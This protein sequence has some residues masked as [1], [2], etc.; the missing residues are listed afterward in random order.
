M[1]AKSADIGAA[2]HGSDT[3]EIGKCYQQRHNEYKRLIVDVSHYMVEAYL[4]HR[5]L[6]EHEDQLAAKID[7]GTE[8][9]I[10][11]QLLVYGHNE[12]AT[13]VTSDA[14][15]TDY[16]DYLR[17]NTATLPAQRYLQGLEII[18]GGD[19]ARGITWVELYA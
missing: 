13:K 7:E 2:L 11:F 17:K 8:K 9:R 5:K 1:Y 16:P 6:T 12:H 19:G 18:P 10:E 15:I 4:I 14:S 3:I